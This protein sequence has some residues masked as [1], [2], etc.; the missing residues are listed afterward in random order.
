M[1]DDDMN[2]DI[3]GIPEVP[4]FHFANCRIK[5][6]TFTVYR[7]GF[8]CRWASVCILSQ[9]PFIFIFAVYTQVVRTEYLDLNDFP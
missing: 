8:M 2:K 5:R 9:L 4:D 3:H 1:V 7:T 6:F